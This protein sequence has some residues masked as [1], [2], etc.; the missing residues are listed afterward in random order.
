MSRCPDTAK[1]LISILRHSH[2][3]LLSASSSKTPGHFKDKNNRTGSTEF[4]DWQ[5]VQGTLKKGFELYS[6]LR[7]PF[8]KAT[9]MMFLIS[10]VH[11]F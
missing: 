8:A 10:E 2:S 3:I 11:P 4:V 9:Y 6:I 1:Q 5:L 7:N